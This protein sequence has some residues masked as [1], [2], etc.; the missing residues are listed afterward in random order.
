MTNKTQKTVR[1]ELNEWYDRE[2][3]ELGLRKATVRTVH[4]ADDDSPPVYRVDAD[5]PTF[6]KDLER[7]FRLNVAR[8]RRDNKRIVGVTDFVP[9]KRGAT[10]SLD[11]RRSE[12]LGEE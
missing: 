3:H 7:L 2:T 1:D 8:A 11:T 5:S 10:R 12:R 9:R 6:G 4:R